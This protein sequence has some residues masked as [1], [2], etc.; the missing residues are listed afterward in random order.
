MP[1]QIVR[2]EDVVE[3]LDDRI[4][5][6]Q[7]HPKIFVVTRDIYDQILAKI[8]LQVCSPAQKAAFDHTLTDPSASN[9]VV[10]KDDI[11]TYYPQEDLGDF[12]DAVYNLVDL[13][14]SG[15]HTNDM[16]PVLAENAIYRWDGS[17]WQPFIRTG[18][19]DHTQLTLQN[20][21]SNYLH[22]SLS[23][24]SSLGTQSH[25]HINNII[26]DAIISVGSGII[27][28]DAERSRLPTTDEKDALAGISSYTFSLSPAASASAGDVYANNGNI[29]TVSYTIA[30]KPTLICLGTEIPTVSGTLV[31][32]S[33]TGDASI[34]FTSYIS[35]YVPPASTNRYVT[36][37]DPRLNTIKNPYVTFGQTGTGTTYQGNTIVDLQ[38]A[39]THLGSSGDVDFID[40]LEVLPATYT[41]DEINYLGIGWFDTKPIMIEA[42]ALRESVIQ[43]APQ[44]S[45]STAF[46]I[47]AGDGRVIIRGLTFELGGTATLGMLIDRDDTII[48]DC[49]FT[50]QTF[51]VPIGNIG[52]RIN[53]NNVNIRRCIF[54]GNLAQG[55]DVLGDN[56]LVESC[57]FDMANNL[58]SAISVAGN[59]CQITSCAVSR[60]SFSVAALV[61]DTIFD[62]NR[63]TSN[64]SFIDAGVNTRWLGGV[65]QDHQQAYIG[66]TRTV[67]LVNSHGDFRGA[68]ETP[69]L[70]ALADPYT[71]EI[72]VLDG[73][74]TFSSPV[75]IPAG[76]SLRCVRKGTVTISGGNCFVL[77]SF[78]KLYGFIFSVTGA[79][80][81]TAT[82]QS[83]IEIRDCV[84]TMNGPDVATQYAINAS[85]VTDFIV[86]GCK[87]AGTR[88]VKLTGSSRAKIVHNIFSSTVYSV[89]TDA[90]TNDL[91][92]AENTE[93]GSVCSLAGSRALV[94]GNHFL[95][96]LPTKLGTVDSLW[97]GNYPP[98]ANN[99]DGIDTIIRSMGDLL[100]PVTSTGAERSS[101]L[102]TASLAF[103]ETGTPTV[104]TPPILLGA[105]IDRTQGYTLTLN[106]TAAVF[107]GN[108][109]WEIS[110]VFRDRASLASDL[111]TPIVKTILSARTHLTV[112][113]EETTTVT[114]SSSEF[115]YI[116]GVD[117][118][119]V[120]F[121]I[122][123][124]G[125]DV[126]DSMAG[127]SYLTEVFV[128]LA[129][130]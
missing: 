40:A 71:T 37:I 78:T 113:Q 49:T 9:P 57:R 107:S 43:I 128:T 101:F 27:I 83:N 96:S 109:L 102:G 36:S 38:A 112:R 108:V 111:G 25:S 124:L 91:H 45:G 121:I 84:L 16:R 14:T 123:R 99:D 5:A 115:G 23:E 4:L 127:I 42:L 47:S 93:E 50:T 126:T 85:D 13:P 103:L 129:R 69:F 92:Y 6:S 53:A 39:L 104:V 54:N 61:E 95:G 15:N 1:Q 62:K 89:T 34:L 32:I 97:I 88:G 94:R 60:G 22:I 28:S 48:E 77:G 68:T 66:R 51:P 19:I 56:C 63:M 52:I 59:N 58:Y 105:R 87:I 35:S 90:T 70:A 10:L 24:L 79:S 100:R 122:R 76:K 120:S 110:A 98:E 17:A 55:I 26:L 67:G 75:T 18:T 117:P 114:F 3:C 44:P 73:T 119:H 41:N 80:G 64:T 74:Y 29:F 81:I 86:Q 125:D 46:T 12:R 11:E 7:D 106:W 116:V 65:A 82:S 31:K 130:D 118:T 72:E 20:G 21:D 2:T 33:G 30:V 8:E